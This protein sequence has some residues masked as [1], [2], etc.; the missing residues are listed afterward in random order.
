MSMTDV[1]NIAGVSQST[2][3][4]VV[5]GRSFVKEST[6][7]RVIAAMKELGYSAPPLERRSGRNPAIEQR[8]NTGLLAMLVNRNGM[9]LHAEFVSELFLAAQR[10]AN[11]EGFAMI[12]HYLLPDQ[13][14]P[15]VFDKVDGYLLVGGISDPAT[16]KAV[17]QRAFV[18]LTSVW[19]EGGASVLTGNEKVGQ[20]AAEYLISRGHERLAFFSVETGNPSYEARG[21]AF[22]KAARSQGIKATR[23]GTGI[24]RKKADTVYSLP[25]L[26]EKLR[27]L[28][29]RFRSTHQRATG[30]FCPSD[31]TTALSYRLL[32]QQNL[33]PGTDFEFVSCDHEST[34][35]TGL[36]PRPATIDLG[37]ETRAQLAIQHLANSLREGNVRSG[38]R[39]TIEP[40]LIP[41]DGGPKPSES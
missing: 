30:I 7:S 3:S 23:Y 35:L 5:N 11:E 15:Q 28:I 13:P 32:L 38:V 36:Y 17:T 14:L 1:A 8:P 33:Q 37:I 34:Y 21:I 6:R 22:L 29:Q 27:P 20:L 39:L 2:V 25:I 24:A 41:G 12:F 26:E 18:S 10:A 4:R 19:S 9:N 31:A 16:T 40:R